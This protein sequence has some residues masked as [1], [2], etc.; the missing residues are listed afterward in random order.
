MDILIIDNTPDA[1]WVTNTGMFPFAHGMRPGVRF[2]P[3]VA[4]KIRP[5]LKHQTVMKDEKTGEEIQVE[6]EIDDPWVKGQ[7]LI[8]ACPNP[9]ETAAEMPAQIKPETV[10]RDNSK[11]KRQPK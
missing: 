3:G 11:S 1:T 5:K 9:T 2:E 10:L 8:V 7:A 6:T 4:V